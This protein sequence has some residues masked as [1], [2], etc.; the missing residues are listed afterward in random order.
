MWMHAHKKRSFMRRLWCFAFPQQEAPCWSSGAWGTG[1]LQG[2]G[3]AAGLQRDHD[4]TC[5]TLQGK[6]PRAD[7]LG[8]E[9]A[10]DRQ[11][12]LAQC[13]N[14][15][16]AGPERE[17]ALQ[18]LHTPTRTVLPAPFWSDFHS[19]G[20]PV[21][22]AWK[23]ALPKLS[24]G[25]NTWWT[26]PTGYQPTDCKMQ[27]VKVNSTNTQWL[28]LLPFQHLEVVCKFLLIEK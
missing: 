1:N 11:E 13:K 10:E 18:V 5:W 14:Y 23:T 8:I 3:K 6:G 15:P 24:W 16:A 12:A 7:K 26:R 22:P 19:L 27:M 28:K 25:S 4:S 17:L 20:V 21:H 2:R 9:G